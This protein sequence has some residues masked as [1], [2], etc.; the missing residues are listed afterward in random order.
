MVKCIR[1]LGNSS[2]DINPIQ[3][4]LLYRCC[5]LPIMLYGFQLWFYNR[6]PL[7]YPMKILGKMQRRA[8]IWILGAFKTSPTDGLKAIAGLILIKF[9]I[10]KLTFRSQLWSAALLKNYLIRS[11]MDDSHNS[12]TNHSPHSIKWFTKRQ[13]SNI[14][15]H[16]INSNNKLFG[17]SPS[18][19][20][21]NPEFIPGSRVVDIFPDRFSFNLANK[22]INDNLHTQQLNNMTLQSSSS[23]NMAI[24]VTDVSVKNDIATSIF[25]IH[26]FNQP[27]IKTVHH[28]A[29][30]TSTEAKLF[31]IRCSI[32]NISKIIVVT[33]SIH[34]ARK[35]FDDKYNP[36]QIHSTAVLHELRHFF[37]AGQENSIEFW[38]CPSCL[39][40]RLHKLVNKKSKSFNPLSSLLSKISWDFCRKTDSD[41]IINLW[42]M[43]FQASDGKGKNFLDLANINNNT[44]E[45][46]YIKGGP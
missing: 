24:I 7:L 34:A 45:L 32:E 19:S 25:H 18:F 3:K 29:F 37:A 22:G 27:M 30:V 23:P 11:L 20:P 6:A 26:T 35:I 8:A 42:K 9:H 4:R 1:L 44:I 17:V 13:K 41:N 38:E 2:W 16:L 10:Q 28:A 5:I 33:N 12:L 15:G 46:L 36:Y 14:K 31:T 43:T 39:K 21:L 40:W